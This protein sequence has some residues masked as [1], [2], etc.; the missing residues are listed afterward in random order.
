VNLI[1]YLYKPRHHVSVIIRSH[2]QEVISEM[3]AWSSSL[4]MLN[5][6]TKCCLC[7]YSLKMATFFYVLL[8]VHLSIYI[9]LFNQLDA[10]N[11]FHSK[12]YFMPVHVSSTC[13]HHQ[14]VKIA[15]YNIWYLHTYRCRCDDT[16]PIGVMLP[17][18]SNRNEYQEHF[19][20]GKGG[21]CVSSHL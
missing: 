1:Q 13:V 18:V 2:H 17:D 10:Q 16:T 14:E 3:Y 19:L 5:I 9:S 11:L 6:L 21:R 20:G 7:L 15:L 8:T 4:T 12:F